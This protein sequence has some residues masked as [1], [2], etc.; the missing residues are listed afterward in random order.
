MY[1]EIYLT[2]H[3]I[4]SVMNCTLNGIYI[5]RKYSQYI[6]ASLP[7]SPSQSFCTNMYTVQQ[8]LK[9]HY[10]QEQQL[11]SLH[12][13]LYLELLSNGKRASFP[14]AFSGGWFTQSFSF[15]V[16]KVS[17]NSPI[18][19]RNQKIY[20]FLLLHIYTIVTSNLSSYM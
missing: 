4:N 13:A 10:V 12:N 2:K 17:G 9:Y 14:P 1:F 6:I 18:L 20:I 7:T 11:N 19:G 16:L 3:T 8:L 15:P 5:I